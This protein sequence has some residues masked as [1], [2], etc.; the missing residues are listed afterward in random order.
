MKRARARLRVRRVGEFRLPG[1]AFT[2]HPHRSF[3][4]HATDG[5]ATVAAPTVVRV[6]DGSGL[7][8]DGLL[9]GASAVAKA[10]FRM[11]LQNLFLERN[12]A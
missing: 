1:S 3:K 10:R 5:S 7:S 4:R 12:N 6:P 11:M 2:D 9:G 8:G